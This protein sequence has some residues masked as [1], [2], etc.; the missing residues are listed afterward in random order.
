MCCLPHK[1]IFVKKLNK[2]ISYQNVTRSMFDLILLLLL[3]LNCL[4]FFNSL[5]PLPFVTV[6]PCKPK[7]DPVR[8]AFGSYFDLYMDL[9]GGSFFG[10]CIKL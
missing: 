2:N 9:G 3:F 7:V 8:G 1:S 6:V 5:I 10:F 4:T